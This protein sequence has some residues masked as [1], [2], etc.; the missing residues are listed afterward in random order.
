M[1]VT[2]TKMKYAKRFFQLILPLLLLAAA[3]AGLVL[4]LTGQRQQRQ[5]ELLSSMGFL[6]DTTG[7]SVT[8][9]EGGDFPGAPGLSQE[10][11][12]ARL[13]EVLA[14]A[15]EA[16]FSA[17]F[18]QVRADGAAFYGSK[19]YDLHPSLSGVK[20]T[21]GTF[22]PL[23]YLC[24][25]GLEER[26]LLYAV[27]DASDLAADLPKGD[28]VSRLADSTAEL[29]KKYP[30]GGILLTGLDEVPEEALREALSAVKDRLKRDAPDL[31]LGLLFEGD[32]PVTPQTVSTLTGDGTLDVVV[33]RIGG[34][35]VPQAGETAFQDILARWGDAAAS[36]ARFLPAL[37]APDQGEDGELRLLMASMEEGVSGGML[38]HYGSLKAHPEALEAAVSLLFSPKGEVPDLSFSIPKSLA[39]TYPA[40]DVSVT[41]ASI[42]LMGTSDPERPLTLDGE[43][44]ERS[45]AKGTW[46]SLQ[47]LEQGENTFTLRQGEETVSVT[48]TRYTGGGPAPI[49]GLTEG[50]LFPRYSCGV[51]SN[52]KLTLSCMGPAGGTVTAALNGKTI[53][54]TQE[55]NA[56]DGTPAAFRG[57]MT[58]SPS[59][60]DAG[61]TT[62]IGT[63]TYLLRYEGKET[64]YRSQGEVYVAGRSVPLVIENTA[65]LSAVLTDPDDDE[66][67]IGSLKPGAVA[68]VVETVRTSRSG[69]ITLAY[70][71]RGS[72]YILAGTPA[73]GPMV[74]VVEG[75]P[76]ALGMK[77][78]S[79][80]AALE[81][82]GSIT[83]ALGEG[84]P[85][86]LTS[87]AGDAIILDCLTT[88]VEES[89]LE[90]LQANDYINSA[91]LS[92][93]QN[94]SRLTLE[95]G[96]GLWGYDLYYREGMT[97]LYLKPAPKRGEDYGKPLAGITVLLDAGHGGSD[98]GAM[99]VAGSGGPAEADLNLA[100][101]GAVKYR[102]EQLGAT[103][104]LTRR[105]DS[106]LSLY[107]RVEIATAV[108]PDI[109]LSIHHNS[110]VLTGNMNQARRMECYYYEESSRPFA[111]A[112]MARL[113]DAVARPGTEPEQA[114]YY[115][116]RQ[117]GN[118]AVLLEVGFMVNP[119]EYE[120]CTDRVTILRTACAVAEAVLDIM[121]GE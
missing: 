27:A 6:G 70:K 26:V 69:V 103:V 108:R 80:A 94:G 97:I 92:S 90:A 81:R 107:D 83:I 96:K 112:L 40:G 36:S 59:D 116:T 23:E 16:R 120:E 52:A 89:Q 47:K 35:V 9:G 56:G 121:P 64:T 118:P 30:L 39:V 99:G 54:L 55:G 51:D 101:T 12:K 20:G 28:A 57:T 49:S 88:T 29:G 72:G 3:G 113:P 66:S 1:E 79:I 46:G 75:P 33:P 98:P 109:F 68:E 91:T 73:M 44:L 10:E 111:E 22:D 2:A 8:A 24:G 61:T 67:I 17:V 85:P 19:Y 74:R 60:Y 93:I 114:R 13:E 100:V 18:F 41:D 11:L 119:L 77:I 71:L 37:P 63:V 105:D 4:W 117:T 82:D 48:V 45:T 58:L 106:Q 102:L 65:Q 43:E 62:S 87:R 76:P 14:L 31:P 84:T 50:S 78:N 7:F 86:V 38:E 42:F 32:G 95:P 104:A 34:P 25:R 115:V 5:H 21:L 110:G 53:T 15:K